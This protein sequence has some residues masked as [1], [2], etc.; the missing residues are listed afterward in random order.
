MSFITALDK[1]RRKPYGG[2]Q[3]EGPIATWYARTTRDRGDFPITAQTIAN[4]LPHGGAVLEVAP[5]PGYLAVQ[6]ARLGGFQI[7]GLDISRS[8]VRIASDNARQ[9]GVAIDFRHGD[10][11]HMPYPSDSFDYV[12]CQAAFKNF[13]DPVAELDEMHRVLRPGGHV[14]IFD[15]RKDAPAEAIDAEIRGMH[16]SPLSAWVTGLTFRFGLLRAALPLERLEGFV[17]K[18]RFG[19]GDIVADGIGF[20]LKLAKSATS[21]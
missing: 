14:S 6:L 5:G 12:V 10:V 21:S 8:F 7:S 19:Y 9:A 1:T 17:A 13:P 16:L 2:V 11:A 18:S 20:E 3:M 15:L 4:R